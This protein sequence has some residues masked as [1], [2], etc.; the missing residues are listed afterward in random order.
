MSIIVIKFIVVLSY[1]R[2]DIIILV[3]VLLLILL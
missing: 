1:Y 3:D 2:V